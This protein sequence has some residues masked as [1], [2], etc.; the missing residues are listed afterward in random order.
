VLDGVFSQRV[1]VFFVPR[2]FPF[3][4]LR[5][6]AGHAEQKTTAIYTVVVLIRTKKPVRVAGSGMNK[7]VAIDHRAHCIV[8]NVVS[9]YRI[10]IICVH[11]LELALDDGTLCS[12]PL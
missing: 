1:A 3:F 8:E 2:R 10:T 5:A 9:S 7:W 12:L 6:A 4:V 11:G